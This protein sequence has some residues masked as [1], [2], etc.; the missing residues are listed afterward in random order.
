METTLTATEVRILGCL[1]E[2]ETTTP[3]YYPLTLNALTNACNQKSNR[4]PVVSFE[5]T[6]VIRG[7][8]ELQKKGLSEK[9][10]KADS[11]V[12]KYQHLFG[13]KYGLSPQEVSV[14]CVLMLRGPQTIGEI[15]GRAERMY[16][17]KGIQDV[18]GV[19]NILI[20]KQPPL[21]LKLPR[22]IGR[23]ESRYMHLLSGEPNIQDTD[24]PVEAA[25]LQVQA[26]N[27]RIAKLEDE[28]A[29]LRRGLDALK[30]GFDDLKS[31]FE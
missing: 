31:Q 11:R 6:T 27:E 29:T 13:K 8:E 7:L 9:I 5:E 15:R 3:D 2:K 20:V 14:I 21:V 1:I 10:Y 25:A 28:V 19:V 18:E 23:K 24:P 30:K 17:F 16:K 26:E 4:N 22:Q 12:P